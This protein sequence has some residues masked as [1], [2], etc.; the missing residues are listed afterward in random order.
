MQ[1]FDPQRNVRA[2]QLTF[3]V[4]VHLSEEAGG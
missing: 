4:Q 1:M 2:Y 3:L